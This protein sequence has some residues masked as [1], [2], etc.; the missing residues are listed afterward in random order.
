MIGKGCFLYKFIYICAE[1]FALFNDVPESKSQASKST[2]QPLAPL[3]GWNSWNGFGCNIN[4]TIILNQAK[5]LVSLGL[6]EAGYQMVV[7]DDCYQEKSRDART[8]KLQVSAEKFPLGMLNLSREIH[9]LGLHV[10]IYSSAGTRTCGGFPGSLDN[11]EID[12]KTFAEWEIDYLKYDNCF[13][14]GRHGTPL[15][16][17]DRYKKMGDALL[18]INRNIS[19]AICNWGQ[20]QVWNFAQTIASSWRI[21]GDIAPVFSGYDDRCPCTS[22]GINNFL[23]PLNQTLG[24]NRGFNL[25]RLF[26][27]VCRRL[28]DARFSLL[29][30]EHSRKSSTFTPEKCSWRV[31]GSGHVGSG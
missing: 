8:G 11:E 24:N 12:A 15:L 3:M 21:S 13:N 6:R 5:L 25:L 2:R 4:H 16:S 18:K 19:F 28:L 27:Y 14:Q 1:A 7:I 20:D 30:P 26:A 17:Y 9:A 31:C 10:G 22:A 23:T 29:H